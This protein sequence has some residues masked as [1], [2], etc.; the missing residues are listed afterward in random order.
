M[1]KRTLSA[2]AAAS[3]LALLAACGGGGDE[4]AAATPGDTTIPST[5]ADDSS[6]VE[7]ILTPSYAASSEEY[8]AYRLLNNERV[9]CGF[10]SLRQN[11]QLDQAAQAH[12]DW[13]ILNN[14][15][16]HYES[17]SYPSG[18]TG[19]YPAD[20]A[21]AAG[22]STT[23]AVGEGIAFGSNGTKIGRGEAGVRELLAG[24]YHAIGVL[25]PMK[26][27][28]ISVREPADVGASTV[29]VPT[30]I[31]TGTKDG[32]QLLAADAV[33][34]YP[35]DGT[36][37]VDYA[38]EDEEPNPVPGRNL[39]TQPLGHPVTVM[40]RYGQVLVINTASMHRVSDGAE[41]VL[42]AP[43]TGDS[44]PNGRLANAPQI[45]YVLPDAPLQPQTS[46]RVSISGTNNGAAFQKTFTFTTGN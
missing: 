5:P 23:Y 41:V 42:R 32:Y 26:D 31:V 40:A 27:I 28:G 45:G 20:R 25:Q 2:V 17:A 16:S 43:V 34:T 39:S 37:G 36:A 8:A 9:R 44:D 33:V 29:I 6:M 15:Y 14:L 46:Y 12:A 19:V 24:V 11:A 3:A 10:G 38:L 1:T 21:S 22:Y 18:F 35:C 7:A 13:M 4:T 30:E